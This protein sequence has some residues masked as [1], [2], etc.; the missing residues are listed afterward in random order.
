MRLIALVALSTAL[1]SAA[2]FRAGAAQVDITPP[3]GAPMAGYYSNRAASG[4][5]DPLHAKAIVVQKDGVTAA[6][7]ACDLA[8]LP[9]DIAQDARRRIRE[10]LNI[11]EAHVMIS[12]TH[13]HTGPVLLS[14]PTRYNLEGEMKRIGLE[15]TASLG[16]KIAEAVRLAHAVLQPARVMAGVG[17]EDSLTFNR[18]FHMKDGTVSWNP[19]KQ[20]PRID[21]PAGPI[22]GSV[23]VIYFEAADGSPIAIHVNY[24]L[25]LDTVGGT[26]YSA[27][28]PYTLSN[29]LSAA[30]GKELVTVFTIGCAGNLNHRDISSKD[31]QK[32]NG[33]AARIGAVLAGEVLKT[34][35]HAQPV[36][37]TAIGVSS[38]T[39]QL[40][41]PSVQPS[42]IDW[43]RTV[44][45][46]FGKPDAA[47]FMD[48]VKAF[49]I[50]DV[51]ERKG[52]PLEAEVQAIAFGKD[53]GFVAL[54]GEIF[55]EHGLAIRTASPYR[56]TSIVELANG[57]VGYVP[58]RK[59]FPQGAYEVV[60]ARTAEGSGEMMVDSA[61]RQLIDLWSKH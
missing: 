20:D 57:S 34:L 25:H 40:P 12:A 44:A 38:E 60:S 18:R 50:I 47:P 24:A 6:L 43:A 27:D 4:V 35:K 14:G 42:E 58:D 46:S 59:A 17:R 30:K 31:P 15:Y 19:A 49:K 16:A 48:L 22:D 39:L 52:K 3:Q 13:T 51:V 26:E 41:L 45:A 23:P 7:V 28:Y 29:I 54:P 33:E 11:P 37:I 61:T 32:G 9:R 55:V 1:L 5:H 36:E 53:V 2:D 10:T 8:S 21:R 56:Y